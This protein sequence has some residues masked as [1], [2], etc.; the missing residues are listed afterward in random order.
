MTVLDCLILLVRIVEVG[1]RKVGLMFRE[2]YW[3]IS[4]AEGKY[5]LVHSHLFSVR[6]VGRKVP[7]V[8]SAGYPLSV[9]YR[10]RD[11]WGRWRI[12]LALS[13]ESLFSYVLRVDVP[14][15][16]TNSRSVMTVWSEHYL[17]WLIQR[18][19][20]VSRVVVARTALPDLRIPG[21][22]S[23]GRTVGYIGRD[24]NRKGGLVACQVLSQLRA[25]DPSW[26]MILVTSANATCP[27]DQEGI[28]YYFDVPRSEILKELLPRIDILLLITNSDCGAPFGVLEA[29]QAATLVMISDYPWLDEHLIEPAVA[30]VTT[31]VAAATERI[32]S[33][34]AES[35][36]KSQHAAFR[37]WQSEF[38]M[39]VLG[40]SLSRAYGLAHEMSEECL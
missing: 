34:D 21:K 30:R 9:L 37:L 27:R 25:V 26:H 3:F 5:D 33:L 1:L 19:I 18:K 12:R 6:Q 40:R 7:V 14:W 15:L 31:D 32:L 24:F 17:R 10:D 29:L 39:S 22:S 13:L 35:L 28:E 16:R 38:S 4:I 36:L 20:D 8:T 2:P 11:G 23:D